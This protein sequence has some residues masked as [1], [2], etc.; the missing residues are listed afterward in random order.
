MIITVIVG[1]ILFLSR[2]FSDHIWSLLEVV[3]VFKNYCALWANM[4]IF[5]L[6]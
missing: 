2:V 1:A 3:R 6:A 4:N 5:I